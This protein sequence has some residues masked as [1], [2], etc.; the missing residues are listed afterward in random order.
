MNHDKYFMT[1]TVNKLDIWHLGTEVWF[2]QLQSLRVYYT[3]KKPW[4]FSIY[5]DTKYFW[6]DHRHW[7]VR[8]EHQ[9]LD[10]VT[11]MIDIKCAD[12]ITCSNIP[13]V[14]WSLARDE[15]LQ[16]LKGFNKLLNKTKSLKSCKRGELSR[17]DT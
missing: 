1:G 15:W 16:F 3:T 9:T 2:D 5:Y 10:V 12:M 6:V 11:G 14:V 13:M 4:N 17:R 7:N 8:Y